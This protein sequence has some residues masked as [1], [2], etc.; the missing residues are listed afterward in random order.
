MA[1]GERYFDDM[2]RPRHFPR[3][4]GDLM[5]SLLRFRKT[6]ELRTSGSPQY[7]GQKTRLH[8][9]LI[10]A[11]AV[12]AGLSHEAVGDAMGLSRSRVTHIIAELESLLSPPPDAD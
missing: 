3:P 8:R 1:D 12:K 6:V 10:I 5:G 2:P 11:L 7:D 9:N 4:I